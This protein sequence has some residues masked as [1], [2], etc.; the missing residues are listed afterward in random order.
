MRHLSLGFGP[1]RLQRREQKNG[2]N[3]VSDTTTEPREEAIMHDYGGWMWLVIDVAMVAVLAAALLY[4][5]GMWRKRY[6][7]RTT[8]EVRDEATERLYRKGQ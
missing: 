5:I 6:R 8:Q 7:D 1:N 2:E 4:G 3:V